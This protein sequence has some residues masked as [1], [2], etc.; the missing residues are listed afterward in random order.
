MDAATG[1]PTTAPLRHA[2]GVR[3]GSFSPDGTRIVTAEEA[4]GEA[5]AARIWDVETGAQL[6]MDLEPG[7]R[8]WRV[9][10]SPDGFRIA[11]AGES[12]T[13]RI[14]DADT[15]RPLTPPLLHGSWVYDAQFSPDGY[16]LAT[17]SVDGLVRI[18]DLVVESD[19]IEIIPDERLYSSHPRGA[20]DA[21]FSADGRKLLTTFFGPAFTSGGALV[22]TDSWQPFLPSL[23]SRHPSSLIAFSPDTTK[24]VMAA[25]SWYNP[26]LTPTPWFWMRSQESSCS[27]SPMTR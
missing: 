7:S 1:S 2:T 26:R 13:A 22:N 3:L 17:A 15:G 16:L 4:I 23:T 19:G 12:T 10:F 14:W 20:V 8:I 18:W 6:G 27:Q 25:G 9:V 5:S 21:R 11:T 24:I